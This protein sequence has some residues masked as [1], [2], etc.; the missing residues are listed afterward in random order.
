MSDYV[1][2]LSAVKKDVKCKIL[3]ISCS[4]CSEHPNTCGNIKNK[5][6]PNTGKEEWENEFDR[7][8]MYENPFA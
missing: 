4:D 5:V 6:D 7:E 2:R 3:P 8:E 1:R